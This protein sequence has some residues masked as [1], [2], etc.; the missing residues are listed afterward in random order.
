MFANNQQRVKNRSELV[1]IIENKLM[2]EPR[3]VWL[4]R[5]KCIGVPHGPINNIGET[6]QHPQVCLG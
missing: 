3:D 4:E 1:S 5:F 2:E 6:F